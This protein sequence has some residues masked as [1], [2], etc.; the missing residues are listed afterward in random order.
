[1][2]KAATILFWI[3]LALGVVHLIVSIIIVIGSGML[4]LTGNT[5]EG[6][7]YVAAIIYELLVEGLPLLLQLIFTL[8]VIFGLKS[9]SENIVMEI[10][11][12]V[13]FSGI[14]GIVS[15]FINVG[16]NQIMA[17]MGSYNLADYAVMRSNAGFASFIGSVSRTLFLIA[18]TFAI[19]YKKVEMV[20]I[21]R[22]QEEE[23]V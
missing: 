18:N 16:M 12:I 7:T 8:V 17:G 5:T 13:A 15:W 14:F 4:N 23:D 10:I 20:D 1:M 2:K 21:R 22:I 19:A 3:S 9:Y 11:A 6:A